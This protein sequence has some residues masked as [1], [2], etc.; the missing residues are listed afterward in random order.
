MYFSKLTHVLALTSLYVGSGLDIKNNL[1][2]FFAFTKEGNKLNK[3]KQCKL[4][5]ISTNYLFLEIQTCFQKRFILTENIL[6][7]FSH[8]E[9]D[10]YFVKEAFGYDVCCLL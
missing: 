3:G 1:F 6:R 8:Q 5:F 2:K 9:P 4:R 7:I 10:W